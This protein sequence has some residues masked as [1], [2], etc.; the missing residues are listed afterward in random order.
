M[1]AN[2]W[3]QKRPV[4][5]NDQTPQNTQK[6]VL[7]TEAEDKSK[8]TG[9]NARID[10]FDNCF[11][12]KDYLMHLETVLEAGLE[13]ETKIYQQSESDIEVSDVPQTLKL[14]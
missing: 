4:E 10:T 12:E 1:T 13:T 11:K 6:P 14:E 3:R 8:F 5:R 9:S 2:D 7:E